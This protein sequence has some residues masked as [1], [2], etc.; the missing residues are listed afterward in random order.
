MEQALA[1]YVKAGSISFEAAMG[2]SSKPDEL[3][4][5]IGAAPAG[6]KAGAR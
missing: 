4:R 1:N 6:A 5:I 3:Q 2:K